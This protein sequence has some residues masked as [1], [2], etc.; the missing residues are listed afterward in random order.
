[1]FPVHIYSD[2]L[3][4][5]HVHSN[6][7]I[8]L[9]WSDPSDKPGISANGNR[10]AGC[11]YG[12]DIVHSFLARNKLK[13]IIRAHEVRPDGIGFHADGL[14]VTLFSATHYCGRQNNAGAVIEAS[15]DNAK[16]P[17]I[18]LQAKAIAP[19]IL[20]PELSWNE[21]IVLERPPTPVRDY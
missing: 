18:R 16:Y 6:Q 11:C 8:D 9:L 15:L 7:A 5:D 14:L 2:G 10:G 21:T 13:M 1:M 12:P 19:S 4:I 20:N 17:F 3:E